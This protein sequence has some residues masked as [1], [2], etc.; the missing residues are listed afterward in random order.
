MN[1]HYAQGYQRVFLNDINNIEQRL[2]EYDPDLYLMWNPN[3]GSWLVMDG[4][5]EMA[6]MKIPQVGLPTMDA[7]VYNRIREIHAPGFSAQQVIKEAEEK[8]KREE[9]QFIENMAH[10]FARESKRAFINAYD[11]GRES[12]VSEYVNGV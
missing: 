1:R 5:M 3:D 10:D 8:K 9:K 6:V 4:I 11:Y 12:G 2:Q 7:R